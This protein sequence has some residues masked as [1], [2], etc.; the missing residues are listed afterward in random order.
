MSHG[1]GDELDHGDDGILVD[2]IEEGRKFRHIVELTCERRREIETKSIHMHLRNPV[3]QGIHEQLEGARMLHVQRVA[4]AGVIHVIAA[5]VLDEAVVAAETQHGAQVIPLTGMIVNDIENNLETRRVQRL[6]HLLEFAHLP[7]GVATAGICRVGRKVA[8]GVVAPIIG[9]PFVFQK[10]VVHEMMHRQQFNRGHA[11]FFEV[12]DGKT[13]GPAPCRCRGVLPGYAGRVWRSPSHGLRSRWILAWA[14]SRS[15]SSPQ[16]KASSTTT[17]FW[18]APCIVAFVSLKIGVLAAILR[19]AEHLR[20]PVHQ[21]S[22]MALAEYG[23]SSNLSGLKRCPCE[24]S[25]RP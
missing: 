8:D 22:V 11:E 16:S 5:I 6:D 25:K 3:A 13:D 24:G 19:I 21:A 15:W 12:F 9:K 4:G 23:S 7:T 18:H 14:V 17:D 20:R 10:L 1:F 2:T